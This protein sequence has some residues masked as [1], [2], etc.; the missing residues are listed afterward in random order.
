MNNKE[1]KYNYTY[2]V[3]PTEENFRHYGKVYF[4]V[5]F[6]DDLEDNYICSSKIISKWCIKHP[7][8]YYREIISFFDTK[9]E[10]LK[11][12]YELIY[13]H[14]GKD[15]CLNRRHGGNGGAM[16]PEIAKNIGLKNKGRK[17]SK[18]EIE[19]RRQSMIG[20]ECKQSTKDKISAKNKGNSALGRPGHTITDEQRINYINSKLGENN[21]MYGKKPW[22]YGMKGTK[23]AI[24]GKHRVWDNKELNI[25]HYE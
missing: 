12:E 15:Y 25:Y 11:A 20:H 18:E 23:S 17:Q 1:K 14:L 10:A 2:L 19:K 22:N 16:L 6:T 21:P 24:K 13:P 7:N 4:G 3:I 5:H 9:Q 8:D